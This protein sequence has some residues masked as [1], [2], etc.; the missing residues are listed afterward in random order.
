MSSGTTKNGF[1]EAPPRRVGVHAVITRGDRLL[2]VNRR[3]ETTASRWGLPRGSA[4]PDELPR[5]ALSRVLDER[6]GLRAIPGLWQWRAV[7]FVPAGRNKPVEGT[8]Y[9]YEVPF[10]ENVEPALP[11]DGVFSEARWVKRSAIGELAVGHS[12]RRIEQSLLAAA[13]GKVAE[14]YLG[15]PI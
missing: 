9:V 8:N 15:V 1:T 11:E 7:D 14:L 5:P 12:L 10:P 13:T 6:L 2:M 3:D 4:R